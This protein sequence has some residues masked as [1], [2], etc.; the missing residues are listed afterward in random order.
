MERSNTLEEIDISIVM[1]KP[2]E[3]ITRAI[4]FC[5]SRGITS[6][7]VS[8]KEDATSKFVAIVRAHTYYMEYYLF[9]QYVAISHMNPTNQ[10]YTFKKKLLFDGTN[11]GIIKS[12]KKDFYNSSLD[13]KTS[14]DEFEIFGSCSL[15]KEIKN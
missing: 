6:E 4:E 2:N 15:V 9:I 11:F 13:S 5:K 8:R 1:T 7:I 3:S 14:W 12:N 10:F